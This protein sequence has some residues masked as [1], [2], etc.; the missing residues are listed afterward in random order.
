MK[1]FLR[2]T[3]SSLRIRNFRLYFLGQIVS[4]SGSFMQTIAQ[5]WL[6]LT[7]THSGTALGVTAAF[8]YVPILALA[9]LGGII[10][11]RFPKRRIL[12]LTQ[13]AQGILALILGILILTHVVRLWMIYILALCLGLAN[14]IDNPTRNA[15]VF[16]MVSEKEIRNAVTLNASLFNLCRIAGPAAAGVIIAVAGVA[17][18]F[19]FNAVSFGAVLIAMR[20]MRESELHR[21]P[22]APREKGM[23][24]KGLRYVLSKPELRDTLLILAIVGMLTFEFQVSLPLLAEF[25]F[26][27]GSSGFAT[28]NA[29]M[30][31]GA[32][33]AG[34]LTAR[35]TELAYA[36]LIPVSALFGIA[37]LL[38]AF[39]PTF[40]LAA[41]LMFF[42][43]ALSLRFTAIANGILQ[44]KSAPH[45]RGRVLS[46]WT[47]A[48]LGSTAIGGPIV[49]WA[50]E[51]FGPRWGLAVGGIAAILAAAV[52]AL[53]I[54]HFPVVPAPEA[55][56]GEA[57][58]RAEK[59]VRLL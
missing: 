37:I 27:T 38:A 6:V 26:N 25:A 47:I 21:T 13:A 19:L 55:V 14:M 49:G 41:F 15:F 3:F 28:L 9:P 30:G 18:C 56:L 51:Y 48:Y 44:L 32:V 39:M 53:A 59:D 54:R 42:V 10:A 40:A 16:E 12:Y 7:L 46:L 5:A 1:N 58:V 29:I 23:V 33:A 52:G 4:V 20:M 17:P 57:T 36:R 45:M 35:R 34:F 11:D 8:Q 31:A 2:G 24:R 50:G 22:P 43:G